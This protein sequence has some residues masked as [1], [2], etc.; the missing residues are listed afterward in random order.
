M[1]EWFAD[2]S[3]WIALYPFLFPAERFAVAAEQVDKLLALADVTGRTVLDLCCGPGRHAI[4][5]AKRGFTVTGVDASPFLL[6]QA[7]ARAQAEQVTVE[8]M[9]EDMRRFVRPVVYD[10]VL[11][12]FTSFGFFDN[13]DDD[14]KVLR[15]MY[16]S[17]KPGGACVIDVL[18]K[19]RLARVFQPTTSEQAPDGTLLVQRHEVIDD[20]SRVRNEW[21]LIKD[22][23]ARS[24][25]FCLN[26]YSGQELKDR[27][28][29]AGFR[30]VRLYGDLD[31]NAY[32]TQA[33]R[34]VA[35]AWRDA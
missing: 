35:V 5:L 28:S 12:M 23:Q 9:Q 6:A 13:K 24:F 10:L 27:L 1:P 30:R 2:E 7:R 15:N 33:S 8:W 25:T 4:V 20:W 31:G 16:Q 21:L 34:L 29:Q 32:G 11:S 17:T 26:L 14:L 18:G 22:G 3:F 19:E